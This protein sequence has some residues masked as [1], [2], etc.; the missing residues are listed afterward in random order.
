M[1]RCLI[2]D[3][4]P[5]AQEV[6][7][8]YILRVR[9]LQ[10]VKKC[11]D[12]LQAFEVLRKEKIDL[13]FLD[14]QMP[15]IDGLGFLKSMK[16]TPAVIITTAFP[17]HALESYDFDVVDYLL[18]PI[19]FERF[20]K[21]VNKVMDLKKVPQ[22]DSNEQNPD[23]LFLKV[24][25]K[26]VR[27]NFSDILYIEGMKDYLKVFLKDKFLVV[28]HTMKR[29]EDLIPRNRFVRVHKSYIVSLSAI[30]SIVG[31]YI[32]LNDK[33]IPIGAN[34]KDELIKIVFKLNN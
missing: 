21:A 23:F 4:E 26:L 9:D 24:D 2:I 30:K 6:I 16:I 12:A 31:N 22:A 3:D 10:L 29:F 27:V 5:L 15:V 8:N 17:Q 34:Y 20:L 19:S 28:H 7:E 1:L 33:Q 18:K 13:I 14:I 25:S 11:D 32:E